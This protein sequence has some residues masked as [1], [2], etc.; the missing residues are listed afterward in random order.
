MAHVGIEESVIT[1]KPPRPQFRLTCVTCNPMA[2]ICRVGL[3]TV[4][5]RPMQDLQPT[6]RQGSGFGSPGASLAT[7]RNTGT[8][9]DRLR[10][11]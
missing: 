3:C 8:G 9:A 5:M 7:T 1:A 2:V 10:V 11:R 6:R 4:G